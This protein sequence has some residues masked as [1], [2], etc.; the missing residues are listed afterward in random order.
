MSEV[1]KSGR[2]VIFVSHNMQAVGKLCTK[3][4]YLRNGKMVSKGKIEDVME[5]YI[6]SIGTDNYKYLNNDVN[7]SEG[8]I[9]EATILNHKEEASGEINVGEEWGINIKFKLNTPLKHVIVAAGISGSMDENINT[10]WSSAK[11]LDEG[12]HEVEFINSNILLSAGQYYI[13][14]GLSSSERSIHYLESQL[15]F[16]VVENL[17][18]TLDPRIIRVKNT[19][20]LLN[21]MTEK[22]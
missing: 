4:I 22:N 19:G 20:F 10:T 12:I 6:N 14:L 9:L 17:N 2:T 1:S 15:A 11:D 3:G 8:G 16:L 13:T 7:F 18:P 21:Q 5:D